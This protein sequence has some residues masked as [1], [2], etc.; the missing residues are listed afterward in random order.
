[1]YQ[2]TYTRKMRKECRLRS[3][4]VNFSFYSSLLNLLSREMSW[5]QSSVNSSQKHHPQPSKSKWTSPNPNFPHKMWRY[6]G[7]VPIVGLLHLRNQKRNVMKIRTQNWALLMPR[8]SRELLSS[9]HY[10]TSMMISNRISSLI[11]CPF[12]KEDKRLRH[13]IT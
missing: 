12:H 3:W 1:M 13:I 10:K 8:K 5:T 2:L 11:W 7:L 6:Q 4:R 9:L